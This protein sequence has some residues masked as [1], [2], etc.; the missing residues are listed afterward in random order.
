MFSDITET[1]RS[2]RLFILGAG[3]SA[4]A[5]IPMIGQLLAKAMKSFRL[6]CPGIFER[7]NNYA[8]TCFCVNDKELDYSK[9]NFADLCTFLEYIELREF[10][11]GERW[12]DNG[13]REKLAFRFYLAK[14]II[15]SAPEAN[16]IPILYLE[17]AKQLR[18]TDIIITFNWDPLLEMSLLK[19]GK[20][21]SYNNVEDA[22]IRIY[23]FHGSVN[24]RLGE[25][26]K[27]RLKWKPLG[28][29]KGMME[30]EV[31]YSNELIW[32]SEWR[33]SQPLINDIEPYLVLPGS[34]KAFDVRP[35]AP[36]WYKPEFAFAVTHHVYII[37]LSLSDD[38]F[39]IKS[40]FIHNLPDIDDYTGIPGRVITIINPDIKIR[41]N[42]HFISDCDRV[43][44]IFER[45]SLDH[46]KLMSNSII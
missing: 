32:R 31:Y 25:P 16:K 11:G 37:G 2:S 21:Y 10:G 41:S 44:F 4:E 38:D 30:E 5:G 28:F 13:S 43:R 26:R 7:V 20:S 24:W 8:K 46:I 15:N 22:K 17:F 45:F 42:Y 36:I 23:K 33:G 3:F 27:P 1:I 39:F 12:S 19:V 40:F 14:A 6:E 34:G 35:L 18:K 29:K 9:V